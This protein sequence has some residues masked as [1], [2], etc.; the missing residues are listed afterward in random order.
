MNNSW[1]AYAK[2]ETE[3]SLSYPAELPPWQSDCW[4]FALRAC[5]MFLLISIKQ[6]FSIREPLPENTLSTWNL[7]GQFLGNKTSKQRRN[8]LEIQTLNVSGTL[9]SFSSR[10]QK[11]FLS[12]SVAQYLKRHFA[13]SV[14]FK[15]PLLLVRLCYMLLVWD[16]GKE[17]VFYKVYDPGNC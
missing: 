4:A 10:L 13:N 6:S 3:R 9:C 11:Q 17:T 8:P 14:I 2:A 12:K 5:L 15:D 7:L 1:S 16:S